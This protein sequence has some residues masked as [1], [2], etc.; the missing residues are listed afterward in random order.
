MPKKIFEHEF[1]RYNSLMH[2]LLLALCF[3]TVVVIFEDLGSEMAKEKD[4]IG[5]IIAVFEESC[6]DFVTTNEILPNIERPLLFE[7]PV[8]DQVPNEISSA[9]QIKVRGPP[10]NE[11]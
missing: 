8:V 9:T 3:V 10:L 4:E 1:F 6:D 7:I 5:T 2:N 11:S